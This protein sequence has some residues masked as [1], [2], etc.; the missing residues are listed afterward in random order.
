MARINP[1]PNDNLTLDKQK[2]LDYVKL[3]FANEPKNQNVC[4][5]LFEGYFEAEK[6][7]EV[8]GRGGQ[9]DQEVR[10]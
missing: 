8:G 1:H 10:G 6:R 7:G 5:Q 9:R 2:I 3:L 4:G